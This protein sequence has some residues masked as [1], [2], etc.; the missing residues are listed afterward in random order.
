MIVPTYLQEA[1]VDDKGYPTEA[2]ASFLRNMLQQMQTSLSEEGFLIPSVTDAQ[3]TTIQ[4]S[5]KT[6]TIDPN[7]LTVSAGVRPGTLVFDTQTP[8][9]D[10]V[11]PKGQLYILL[12][13]GTFHPITNT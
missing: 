1:I 9:G 2:F 4:N 8:N 5:F 11:N 3:K 13:D 7:S 6:N 10:M 12:N